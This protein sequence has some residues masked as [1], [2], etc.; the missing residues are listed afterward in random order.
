MCAAVLFV[1]Q[2]LGIK[3]VKFNL[4]YWANSGIIEN[5]FQDEYSDMRPGNT[6]NC[7]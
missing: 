1:R 4:T 6:D 3:S 5:G 2:F 7:G